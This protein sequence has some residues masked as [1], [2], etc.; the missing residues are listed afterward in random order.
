MRARRQGGCLDAD[1]TPLWSPFSSQ[2]E[3]QSDFK[4]TRSYDVFIIIFFLC[5]RIYN[6]F[7]TY[8]MTFEFSDTKN[9]EESN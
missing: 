9:S 4:E 7:K 5:K 3:E 8:I 2:A 6:I 1:P